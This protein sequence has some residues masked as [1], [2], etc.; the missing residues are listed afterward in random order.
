MIKKIFNKKKLLLALIVVLLVLPFAIKAD[1]IE[2]LGAQISDLQKKWQTLEDQRQEIAK[3]LIDRRQAAASLENQIALLNAEIKFAEN[4]IAQ[5]QTKLAQVQLEIKGFNEQISGKET[6][7][8]QQKKI[9]AGFFREVYSTDNQDLLD[10]LLNN[11]NLSEFIDASS[12]MEKVQ[13]KINVSLK[14]LKNSKETLEWERKQ[15]ISKKQ[16]YDSLKVTLIQET[17]DLSNTSG[18][19]KDLLA[20]TKGEQSRYE[21]LLRGIEEQRQEILGNMEELQKKKAKELARIKAKQALPAPNPVAELWHY[22]QTDPRWGNDNIGF[23]KSKLK[24]YGCAIGSLAMIFKYHNVD[25]TPGQ[26]ARQPI[27]YYDLIKWPSTWRGLRLVANEARQRVNWDRVDANI[28]AGNPVIV[29]IRAVGKS[30]GH[31]VVVFAKDSRGYIVNDPMW[32]PNIYLDSTRENIATLY[33][34]TTVVEQMILY[35]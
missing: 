32:G 31:Y 25:I 1:V 19:K 10:V 8:I 13:G 12:A 20:K 22:Y 28:K 35:K 7:I 4:K 18:T 23:S 17:E 34:T 9:L 3:S 2:D 14:D 11:N 29:F 16:E 24:D 27:F 21:K 33:D 6:N 5:T 30:G 15:K 26:L